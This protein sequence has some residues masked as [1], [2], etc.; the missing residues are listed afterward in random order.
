MTGPAYMTEKEFLEFVYEVWLGSQDRTGHFE[1]VHHVDDMAL[2]YTQAIETTV[3]VL[4]ILQ[5]RENA[6]KAAL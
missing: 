3:D 2:S 1:S 4:T 5:A 6:K